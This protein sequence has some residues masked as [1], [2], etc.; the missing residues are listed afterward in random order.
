MEE[1]DDMS[2]IISSLFVIVGLLPL[3]LGKY[4]KKYQIWAQKEAVTY[5]KWMMKQ[6]RKAIEKEERKHK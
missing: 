6:T 1:N 3:L 5:I 4:C 2:T